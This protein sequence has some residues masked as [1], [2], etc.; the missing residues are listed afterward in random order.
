LHHIGGPGIKAAE[1]L[2]NCLNDRYASVRTEA[3]HA[4]GRMEAS[5]AILKRLAETLDDYDPEV[6]VAAA[7]SLIGFGQSAIPV[8]CDRLKTADQ[9]RSE[10]ISKVLHEIEVSENSLQK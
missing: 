5:P 4:L 7:V 3:A 10:R 2:V 8:L 6:R 1:A 9:L